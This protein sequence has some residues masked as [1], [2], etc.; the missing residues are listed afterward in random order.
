MLIERLAEWPN[1]QFAR[2]TWTDLNGAWRFRY[3]DRDEGIA[4]GWF[5]SLAPFDRTIVVPF[6]P[7]SP[8]S[9]IGD[10]RYHPILWYGR[11]FEDTRVSDEDR[12]LVCFGAVDYAATV[13]VDG[14][15][16]GEH[17]GGQTPFSIDVTDALR[18]G[19]SAHTLIVRAF[20]DPLD[21]EQPR[22]KQDWLEKPHVIWYHRTSGIWQS[23]WTE[24][25][26]A[27][28]IATIRW[29][30]DPAT[31]LIGFEAELTGAPRT[32]T[33]LAI[34]LEFDGDPVS[35]VIVSAHDRTV[36]GQIELGAARKTMDIGRLR[37]SPENPALFGATLT[38]TSGDVR[39]VVHSYLG[40]RTIETT[41]GHFRINGRPYFLR[42]V[43]NQG[44]WPESH[45][46]A[47][48][49]VLKREVELIQE[50]GF[51]GARIHQKIEDPRFL[52][53]ADRKGL[54]IWGES[55]N[56]FT[57]SELAIDRHADEWR[58]A[59]LRDRNHPSIIAWTPFNE[60]WGVGEIGHSAAQR[61]AVR[62][63][64]H[65]THQLD[66]TRPVI[67]NDGWEHAAGD[68]FTIHDYTWDA[69]LLRSRYG[70][71]GQLEETVGSYFPASRLLTVGGFD[72][73]GLPVI[74]SEF[75]GVS[76][77]P[78]AGEEWF[79]YGKVKT[80]E[81]YLERY[82]ALVAALSESEILCGFCY[83]QLT[84]TMQETN[85]LLTE[86]RQ[87][88][89]PFARLAAATRNEPDPGP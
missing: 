37:W 11:E 1:P 22:G 69:E 89:L 10:T 52:Y 86:D 62:A 73:T 50:L 51:N 35:Q 76:F 6:P 56:A 75:G 15:R 55:A 58:E 64:Y 14:Q 82:R 18:T 36:R 66:G 34:D 83:T 28:R 59:V 26:P 79:G 3:D 61:H 43:L 65:R 9:G 81:E 60:S 17:R 87:P 84:D 38:L 16:V 20:D 2:P 49:E 54:L 74:V 29:Q 40:L 88:K 78:D 4:A 30:F 72:H 24:T 63:I 80:R 45:L 23:V 31:W 67:G 85:G 33:S 47:P 41:N 7:E 70:S 5:T 71:A 39:D 13:W 8:L 48:P 77:A 19:E 21:I 27:V 32:G 12:L 42:L 44:Y 57:F 25:A 53:W 46:A 68:L